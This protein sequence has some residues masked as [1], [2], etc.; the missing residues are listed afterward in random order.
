MDTHKFVDQLYAAIN[1]DRLDDL[2]HLF[3][4]AYVDHTEAYEGV[5][6]RKQQLRAFRA[7]FPDLRVTVHDSL[8]DGDRFASRTT[9]TGTQTGDLMGIPATGMSVTVEAIDIG[10]VVDGRALERWGGLNMMSLL[11]QL[12]VVPAQRLIR[13]AVE[14]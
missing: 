11:T 7:A 2:D 4:P 5:E 8:V 13:A 14:A 3:A 12:G 1:D 9:V 6:A 10:R